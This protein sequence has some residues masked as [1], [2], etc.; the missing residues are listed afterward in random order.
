MAWVCGTL[1]VYLD[2]WMAVRKGLSSAWT[3]WRLHRTLL[4]LG[5]LS[6]LTQQS[7]VLRWTELSYTLRTI[8]AWGW[9]PR[10]V[11][12]PRRSGHHVASRGR[13]NILVIVEWRMSPAAPEPRRASRSCAAVHW[14][15]PRYCCWSNQVALTKWRRCH[16]GPPFFIHLFHP[17]CDRRR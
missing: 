16:L 14:A 5:T 13:S 9:I 4:G 3:D 12:M 8:D 7:R 11:R 17:S 2:V 15:S 6:G 10:G 1:P